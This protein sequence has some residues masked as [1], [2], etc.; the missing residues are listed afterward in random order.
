MKPLALFQNKILRGF[1]KLSGNSPIPGL[2]FIT[3]ELPIEA[4]VHLDFL[5]LFHTIL[6]NPETKVHHIVKYLLMMAD[7]KST[8][9]SHHLK[10]LCIKYELPDPLQ[11]F[12]SPPMTKQA[13]RTLT[14]T[15]VTSF[16]EGEQ[17]AKALSNSN[18]KYLNVQLLG[19]SGKPHP[20]LFYITETREALRFRS[21]MKL[22]SGDFPSYE[23]LGQQRGSDPHCRLCPA[24]IESTQHILTL[25]PATSD[26]RER[27][28]PELQ[29]ILKKIQPSSGILLD[30]LIP[31]DVL[32]QFLL[33]STSINLN[34]RNKIQDSEHPKL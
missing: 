20:A 31:K 2:F 8:T 33:D 34:T 27:L 7:E 18:L 19:L 6:I 4:T 23:L 22:L 11:L 13:W 32:T 5:N 25:C 16:H 10:L 29:N 30:H 9:W 21:H 15:R 24:P 12:E 17:R 3:G 1:L 14:W 28:F 26:E